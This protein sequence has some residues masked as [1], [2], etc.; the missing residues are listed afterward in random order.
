MSVSET[1][2]AGVKP[3]VVIADSPAVAELSA[4]LVEITPALRAEWGDNNR[5]FPAR[6]AWQ[7]ALHAVGWAAPAWPVE[8][9]GLALGVR[10]RVACALKLAEAGASH[11]AG[12][13]GLNNVGHALMAFGSDAQKASLPK[14]LSTEEIWCQGFSEP[15]AGSDLASLRTRA[16]I[17]GD[18]FVI[19]GQKIWTS[20]GMH[21]TD[22]LLLARTDPNAAKHAGISAITLDM[23]SPGIERREIKQITGESDFAE[24]FFTDVRVPVKNL[25]GP[26]NGG[27]GVTTATL[28]HE[29]AGVITMAAEMEYNV[30]K[31][32]LAALSGP[33][34]PSEGARAVVLRE[35]IARC[36]A[37]ARVAGL[38][39]AQAL[40]DAERGAPVGAQQSLIKLVWADT[41]QRVAETLFE[42]ESTGGDYSP[43]AQNYLFSRGTSIAGGTTEILKSLAGERVLGLP[44]EPRA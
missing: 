1:A 2:A 43:S 21:A 19:N 22:M 39:G 41:M 25:L 38:L 36:F 24:V 23:N 28:A 17:D 18:D 34:A 33:N 11:M 3:A 20:E 30:G 27:W 6:L 42:L 9:G 13:L 5:T 8:Q 16:E 14:I 31:Q 10:D 32:L 12:I 26:L 40:A 44:R 4:H 37:D 15:E 35:K 29:R 7:R